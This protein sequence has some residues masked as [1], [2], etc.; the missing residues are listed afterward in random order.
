MLLPAHMGDGQLNVLV[1]RWKLPELPLSISLD[2]VSLVTLFFDDA[3]KDLM[4][5]SSDMTWLCC[6]GLFANP[7]TAWIE[8]GTL[9]PG[10][11][12]RYY[13]PQRGLTST[14]EVAHVNSYIAKLADGRQDIGLIVR[15]TP[16]H[17]SVEDSTAEWIIIRP[18]ILL[19]I[20]I[21]V[22]MSRDYVAMGAVISILVGQTLAVGHTIKD[23]TEPF[24][25]N[26][27]DPIESNIFFLANNVIVIAESPSTLF[28]K[29]C[30][31]RE[32]RKMERPTLVQVFATLFFMIGILLIG[33]A[34]LNT[35]TVYLTGHVI[36]AVLIGLLSRRPLKSRTLNSVR[37][38][39]YE[40]TTPGS[41]KRRRDA[42]LWACE[43]TTRDIEWLRLGNLADR[44]S[45]QFVQD[46]LAPSKGVIPL[47]LV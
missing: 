33:M 22:G 45:L 25:V 14:V 16:Q 46:H 4:H 6:F 8:Y 40:S 17:P 32:Y 9:P 11:G 30:S 24:Q 34:G 2:P 15:L 44:E 12:V 1:P 47:E 29:A 39:V 3:E 43:R 10:H 31:S 37:W 36:Q 23:R 27:S 21:V 38:E 41:L 42:F 35:K 19:A 13:N 7:N 28:V 20:I 5:R 26:A 18:L